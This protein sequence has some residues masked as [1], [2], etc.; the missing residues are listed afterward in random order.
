[1]DE[2]FSYDSMEQIS[3]AADYVASH[4]EAI[5]M[6][7]CLLHA[8]YEEASGH[9]FLSKETKETL[10]REYGVTNAAQF[11][12]VT[13][14]QML[15]PNQNN[16]NIAFVSWIDALLCKVRNRQLPDDGAA[17][18]LHLR[19]T[20]PEYEWDKFIKVDAT[21]KPDVTM[22][23]APIAA[24]LT[25]QLEPPVAEYVEEKTEYMAMLEE[26]FAWFIMSDPIFEHRMREIL[27]DTLTPVERL[28]LALAKFVPS[29][30][31]SVD[32]IANASN[33]PLDARTFMRMACDGDPPRDVTAAFREWWAF[34][35][36]DHPI[37]THDMHI[38]SMAIETV[39][40]F[41]MQEHPRYYTRLCGFLNVK[42]TEHE[43]N[44][45]RWFVER[46]Y[47]SGKV[48]PL[49]H[50]ETA[51]RVLRTWSSL[52]FDPKKL[53]LDICL[54][55]QV[56]DSTTGQKFSREEVDKFVK[57]TLQFDVTEG[58][59]IPGQLA[60]FYCLLRNKLASLK[61]TPA[62]ETYAL[63]RSVEQADG[64][65]PP[66]DADFILARR[67]GWMR[68]YL[69]H[70]LR[71]RVEIYQWCDDK[72]GEAYGL[73]KPTE[74]VP[75][76]ISLVNGELTKDADI[77]GRK[78]QAIIDSHPH[79]KDKFI[80][81]RNRNLFGGFADLLAI[82]LLVDNGFAS[83]V[84]WSYDVETGDWIEAYNWTNNFRFTDVLR[85]PDVPQFDIVSVDD[86]VHP[87]HEQHLRDFL[88]RA[89]TDK[90]VGVAEIAPATR[91][92]LL[93]YAMTHG[94]L[95]T[96]PKFAGIS[97]FELCGIMLRGYRFQDAPRHVGGI[98]AF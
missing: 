72:A 85:V 55:R 34:Y 39:V 30:K 8:T 89:V 77:L 66:H 95:A 28:P 52:T 56:Y 21:R 59:L 63:L 69:K 25:V 2:E 88:M 29:R 65:V 74:G 97:N 7:R 45:A 84:D 24:P 26:L 71:P 76:A 60:R 96:V 93:S 5:G 58:K 4:S 92:Q 6:V 83:F 31:D 50:T 64:N 35:K 79:M 75:R 20:N 61:G 41:C 17:S 73:P 16:P 91:R 43:K 62:F 33:M 80:V 82:R 15:I 48:I 13:I 78:C 36:R 11:C 46:I 1:M 53:T 23:D 37:M 18:L 67:M 14:Q 12:D 68:Y 32:Q 22:T 51:K 38:Y 27:K 94:Y 87:K 42:L 44:V 9:A 19:M 81:L 98:V 3:K 86:S 90:G 57:A 70:P 49:P 47:R 10:A 54:F 40:L